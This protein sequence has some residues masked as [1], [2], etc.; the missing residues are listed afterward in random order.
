M[1][2]HSEDYKLTAVKY[3]LEHNEDMRDTCHI[4]KCKYQSLSRWVKIYKQN[5][6]LYRK[7][8]KIIISKLHLKLK[9]M[10]KNM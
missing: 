6:N 7:T 9:N 4:F 2:H 3:Y 5:G 8:R 10:L 1:K